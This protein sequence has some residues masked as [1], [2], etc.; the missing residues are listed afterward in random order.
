MNGL[1]RFFDSLAGRTLLLVLAV[2]AV[3]EVATF[4]L[5]FQQGRKLHGHQTARHVAG[6]IRL[7]QSLLPGLD[8]RARQRLEAAAPGEQW[9]QLRP[10]GT[11]VPPDAPDS[12]FARR[13]G[14][15]AR[16][17]LGEPVELRQAGQARGSL[18]IGFAAGGERWWLILPPPRFRP[19]GMPPDLWLKLGV[20]LS[21]V[22]LIAGLFVRGIVGPLR[23][24]DA[25]VTAAGDG[26]AHTLIPEGPR[27]VRHL[28]EHYNAMRAQLTQA[29]AEQREM[30][31]GLTHDLRA[32]LA[33][34]RV[35]A[36]LLESDGER[37]GLERDIEDMDRI[38]GQCLSFLRSAP[39]RHE[40]GKTAA[41]A[42][43]TCTP[44]VLADAVS[45]EVAR[46]RELG[47]PVTM[48]VDAAAVSCA[49]AIDHGSLHRLLDNLIDNALQYGAPPV[50]VT[51]TA[52]AA[53]MA[54]SRKGK[55]LPAAETVTAAETA[56]MA[57]TP[58][59]VTLCISDHGRGILPEQR[60]RAFEAFAQIEP[61]R[62]TRGS[63]GLGLAIV[64]R[65][66]EGCG[67]TVLLGEAATGGLAVIMQ[68]PTQPPEA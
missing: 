15:R 48:K 57:E 17:I 59:T 9:L 23:R 43:T 68:F 46:Q 63:C 53:G 58:A 64:R 60:R 21:A 6:Q 54:D 22:S 27:E 66:V 13:L 56:A 14:E 32:P 36:A 67:G 28:A 50:E 8:A 1:R 31:A 12:I 37:A 55:A 18:W 38:V 62:A 10:D 34:M 26:R 20:A 11:D 24:L 3:A 61:A 7:L 65:I 33:R 47:R 4:S 35:R 51:L 40:N 52:E 19:R 39:P 30:L 41:L 5:F 49:V 16:Q 44:L 25:A 42:A 2:V 45:D 29:E